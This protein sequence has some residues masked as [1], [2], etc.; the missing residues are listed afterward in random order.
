MASLFPALPVFMDLVGRS[1]I[2]LAGDCHGVRLARECLQAG[3]GVA[4][5]CLNPCP[6][7]ETVA[8]LRLVRRSWRATDFRNAALVAA[9]CNERR[10][11]RAR[12]SAKAAKAVF[13]ALDNGPGADVTIG[14]TAAVG[15]LTI[16]FTAT[17]LPAPLLA[18]LRRRLDAALPPGL[19]GFLE[20]ATQAPDTGLY[21]QTALAQWESALDAAAA[22][23]TGATAAP[24]DWSSWLDSRFGRGAFARK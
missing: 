13:M 17:G 2:V 11:T 19:A 6:E 12:M 15:P 22:A 10:M 23:A 1:V 16:G 4:M 7:A 5:I 21:G 9:G 24:D 14:E 8:G 3:A 20:A 18:V